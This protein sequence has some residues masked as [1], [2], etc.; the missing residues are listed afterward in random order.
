VGVWHAASRTEI[1]V[2]VAE[3]RGVDQLKVTARRGS[4]VLSLPS[5]SPRLT[6]SHRGAT[7]GERQA[8][9]GAR[10]CWCRRCPHRLGAIAKV[11]ERIDADREAS[12]Y[13]ACPVAE[14]DPLVDIAVMLL[15]AGAGVRRAR[16][17]VPGFAD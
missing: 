2:E 16:R 11:M 17:R 12:N 5:E 4:L 7:G 10:S 9:S 3:P 8:V 15:D 13:E 14:H 1:F 6:R